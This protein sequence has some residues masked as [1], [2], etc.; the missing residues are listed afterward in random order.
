MS[1]LIEVVKIIPVS[2]ERWKKVKNKE[3]RGKIVKKLSKVI[4]FCKKYEQ[5]VIWTQKHSTPLHE[6]NKDVEFS[7]DLPISQVFSA[8]PTSSV[9]RLVP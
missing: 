6:E 2:V 1:Q 3:K 4:F 9:L 8:T 5:K 7:L